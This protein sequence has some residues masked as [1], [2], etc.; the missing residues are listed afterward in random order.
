M[1]PEGI[2]KARSPRAFLG[3][4]KGCFS[5]GKACMRRE[6][7][8]WGPWLNAE[9]LVPCSVSGR[10]R[11]APRKLLGGNRLGQTSDN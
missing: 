4:W 11:M 8:V 5:G 2:P 1:S 6:E 3:A 10:M 7:L 9:E